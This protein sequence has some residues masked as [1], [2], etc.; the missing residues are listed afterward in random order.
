MRSRAFLV[1]FTLF[2]SGSA[3]QAQAAT[4]TTQSVVVSTASANIWQ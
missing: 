3:T 4:S 1:L 2:L